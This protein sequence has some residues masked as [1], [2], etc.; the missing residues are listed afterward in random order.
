MK[1]LHLLLVLCLSGC[2]RL[3]PA[4]FWK[5]F[6]AEHIEKNISDQ[7]PWGGHRTVFWH[8]AKGGY[9]QDAILK[10]AAENDWKLLSMKKIE[11]Q[12]SA[13][14]KLANQS[15][16]ILKDEDFTINY[17]NTDDDL[18]FPGCINNDCILYEFDSGWTRVSEGE[19]VTAYGYILMN[20]NK[21]RMTMVHSWGE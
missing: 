1:K 16:D 15:D 18:G 9:N 21:T 11:A 6:D 5:Y 3:T 12:N 10:F 2:N 19:T 14:P 17:V 8:N 20:Y 4:G 13:G 7:G